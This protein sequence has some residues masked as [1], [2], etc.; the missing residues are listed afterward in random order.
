MVKKAEAVW[1]WPND[2]DSNSDPEGCS[3]GVVTMGEMEMME[4][5]MAEVR[6]AGVT[7]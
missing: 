2:G 7:A 5:A 3:D 4:V 1:L 6:V